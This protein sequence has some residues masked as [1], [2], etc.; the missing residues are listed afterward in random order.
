MKQI[1]LTF[2]FFT[3]FIFSQVG[4]GT[5][6]PNG[7]LDIST[8]NQGLL[9]PRV[10][11]TDIT[12]AAPI[13]NPTNGLAPTISTLVYNSNT[14]S[15]GINSVSP[16]FYFWNGI[17]WIRLIT[18]S[19]WLLN[20]NSNTNSS[21][22]FLGTLDNNDLIFKR[23]NVISG[24]LSEIN[25]TFGV[26]ALKNN[27]TGNYNT[28]IGQNSLE[29]NSTGYQNTAVGKS[30]LM[31]NTTGNYNV[32]LGF[33]ALER[34]TTGYMNI[35]L[36]HQSLYNNLNG[37]SDLAIGKSALERNISG[38][39][40]TAIGNY[41]LFNNQ[42][43]NDNLALGI[44]ALERNVNGNKNIAIGNSSLLVNQNSI[45][46]LS[47]GHESQIANLSGENNISLGNNSLFANQSG[48]NNVAIGYNAYNTG[49]FNNSI[50]LGYNSTITANNQVRL[51]NSSTTS[52]GGFTS[53][54]NVSDKRF[55]K[56][57]NYQ[58]VPGLEFILKLK[59]VTY[60]LNQEYISK[61]LNS[62]NKEI[63]T[64][65]QLQTGFIA[66]EVEITAK[67]LDFDFSGID[68]PKNENDYYGLRYAEFVVPL[69]KAIQEQQQIIE[70]QQK[71]INEL[72]LKI[73]QILKEIKTHP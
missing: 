24:T 64:N 34:N 73:N 59:P 54:T 26:A 4:I 6:T 32:A 10:T 7:A 15:I 42:S 62:H 57:I 9:I 50:A 60:Y 29:F 20:G 35:A 11:L 19:S 52:I 49:N 38:T 55:K 16:G 8:N 66:Q 21:I 12:L 40:N 3:N 68:K 28:A 13:I 65:P 46:C 39:N 45:N 22:N 58:N 56:N 18:E 51:G 67:D 17:K 48:N 5:V 27:T 71:E 30:S 41:T 33:S 31:Q 69:T 37:R 70:N 25:T 44:S 72:K 53:W 23:N 1:I 2:F 63:Q 43:G 47:I 14:T 36:G 61:N